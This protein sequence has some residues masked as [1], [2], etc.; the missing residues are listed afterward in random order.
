MTKTYKGFEIHK[1]TVGNM[2]WNITR[3]GNVVKVGA[4][5]LADAKEFINMRLEVE[6]YD[7]A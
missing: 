2:G 6:A 3:D 7:A 1:Q 5:T 4:P